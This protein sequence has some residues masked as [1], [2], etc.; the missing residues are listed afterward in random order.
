MSLQVRRVPV[1]TVVGLRRQV[2]RPG[3][4]DAT[5][6]AE[7]PLAVH[8]AAYD[9]ADVVG[10]ASVFPEPW[11]GAPPVPP[12]RAAWR[13]RGMAV[14]PAFRRRG[15]GA[16]V[17]DEAVD[18]ARAAGAPVLWANARVDA[19]PFYVARGWCALGDVFVTADT[20]IPHRRVVLVL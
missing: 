20:G 11:P 16:A 3:Q 2:L 7:H 1:E 5:F 14:A 6:G 4:P 17:L 8:V 12:A 15:V 9:G 13:L 19:L 18:A 10:V